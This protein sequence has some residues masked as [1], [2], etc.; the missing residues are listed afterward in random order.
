VAWRGAAQKLQKLLATKF[1][2]LDNRKGRATIRRGEQ[3]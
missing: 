2:R 1:G 3:T